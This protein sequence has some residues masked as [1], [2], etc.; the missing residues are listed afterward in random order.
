MGH[1]FYGDLP[2]RFE[3]KG[4]DFFKLGC[5]LWLTSLILI[6]CSNGPSF[7]MGFYLGFTKTPF[8]LLVGQFQGHYPLLFRP[9]TL[10]FYV[11]LLILPFIYAAFKATEWKW[12]LQGLRLGD[13]RFDSD[14]THGAL[15]VNIWKMIG[16][17]LFVFFAA[18]IV[19]GILVVST[20]I[21]FAIGLENIWLVPA[22]VIMFSYPALGAV[23]R[24]YLVQRIWKIVVS[25]IGIEN[26][27]AADHVVAKGEVAS[28]LG[29]GLA[30]SLDVAGF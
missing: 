10:L 18:A 30:D 3:G 8:A 27:G 4:W 13:V 5:W 6:A 15:I 7:A 20:P 26:L 16:A 17:G 23:W 29:E 9:R 1:T 12:W 24:I 19:S 14:L 25:S 11:S 21:R 2:G 28:A 22:G